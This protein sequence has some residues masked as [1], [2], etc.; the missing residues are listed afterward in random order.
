MIVKQ[1]V[2]E[3]FVDRWS[4]VQRKKQH[5]YRKKKERRI[6]SG[7]SVQSEF[8]GKFSGELGRILPPFLSYQLPSSHQ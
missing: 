2:M 3:D 7:N 6:N 8:C 5:A 1:V 4:M